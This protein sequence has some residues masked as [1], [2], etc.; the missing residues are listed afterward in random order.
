[1]DTKKIR[2]FLLSSQDEIRDED[3]QLTSS[4]EVLEMVEQVES[5]LVDD[6]V[7]GLLSINERDAFEKHYLVTD[8]RRRK[9]ELARDL[10]KLAGLNREAGIAPPVQPRSAKLRWPLPV[11]AAFVAVAL[12]GLYI[13]F[14]EPAGNLAVTEV[15]EVVLE[16]T[17]E[18][19][20]EV[21]SKA[22]TEDDKTTEEE[23][24]SNRKFTPATITLSP[25]LLRSGG[26]E[27]VLSQEETRV[28]FLMK[29]LTEPGA[30]TFSHYSMKVETPEGDSITTSATIVRTSKNAI[31]VSVVGKFERGTYI[32]YLAG[33]DTDGGEEVV[34]EYS[35]KV[36]D[37]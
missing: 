12:L 10:K 4:T 33:I 16:T 9:V 5:D 21:V 1:M 11:A 24:D 30:R 17:P 2:E 23:K 26:N 37:E 32:V 28:P 15:P 36:V 35:F 29:L 20:K 6:Y 27:I 31:T 14:Q 34:A 8:S 3:L 22:A 18:P 13:G 19:P 25:S 7:L